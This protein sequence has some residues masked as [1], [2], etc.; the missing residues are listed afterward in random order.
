MLFMKLRNWICG[1]T[2]SVSCAPISFISR[3]AKPSF[4]STGLRKIQGRSRRPREPAFNMASSWSTR[5]TELQGLLAVPSGP[6][7]NQEM[8]EFN[9]R[10]DI[11]PA[12]QLRLWFELSAVPEEF[13]LY[14]GT[15]LALPLGHRTSIDFDFFSQ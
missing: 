1:S 12:A 13:V 9:P 11:L 6:S 5:A 3:G 8:K 14:R 7:V 4:T 15:A 2:R 10:L